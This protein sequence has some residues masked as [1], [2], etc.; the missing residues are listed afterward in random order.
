MLPEDFRQASV[1]YVKTP[2]RKSERAY[3]NWL[4]WAHSFTA[5][6]TKGENIKVLGKLR[7]LF[8]KPNRQARRFLLTFE[9]EPNK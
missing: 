3:K 6:W 1:P 5:K 4:V 2:E 8:T 7:S 9:R